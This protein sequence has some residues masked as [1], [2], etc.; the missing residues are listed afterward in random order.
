[1]RRERL[2]LHN[3]TQYRDTDWYDMSMGFGGS[4]EITANAECAT[5]IFELGPQTAT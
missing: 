2:V 1:M 3:G 5:Y 4:I